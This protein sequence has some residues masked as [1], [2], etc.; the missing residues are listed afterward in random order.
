MDAAG[1]LYIVNENGGGSIDFYRYDLGQSF[2][3]GLSARF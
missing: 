2:S 1:F 3:F